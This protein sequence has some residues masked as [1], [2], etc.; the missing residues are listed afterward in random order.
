VFV[1]ATIFGLFLVIFYYLYMT[2]ERKYTSQPTL[3]L[4]HGAG[5]CFFMDSGGKGFFGSIDKNSDATKWYRQVATQLGLI[6]SNKPKAILVISAHWESTTPDTVYVTSQKSHKTLFY[7]YYNFPKETYDLKYPCPGSPEL[8][9]KVASLIEKAKLGIKCVEDKERN[10][11]HGVFI[12]LLL[13]YPDADIPV[14]QL[15]L[16][17]TLDAS[18]QFK[19][20]EALSSLR[21]EGV[22]IIGSGQ[23]THGKFSEGKT[24]DD[25]AHSFVS[26]L[27]K[28]ISLKADETI[29]LTDSKFKKEVTREEALLKWENLPYAR[30]AH[31]REEH[32][33]PLHV[34][35][36]SS[37]G[38][39]GKAICD[40]W[41]G[42]M[43][44]VSYIFG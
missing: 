33:L 28:V 38:A 44:L 4:S 42:Q 20:G 2:D 8:A 21:D 14:I 29:L 12:P 24:G 16:L 27:T 11:D 7:D 5:P 19:I 13:V 18:M 34:V 26:D 30:L 43:S 39:G 9:K 40:I 10:L 1:R 3:F 22:L 32:L 36:G 6:G 37:G 31:G 23:A 35:V 25:Q 15:S 17:P 41:A